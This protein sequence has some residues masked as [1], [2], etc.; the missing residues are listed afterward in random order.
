[1]AGAFMLLGI[2]DVSAL[3]CWKGYGSS[4]AALPAFSVGA[5]A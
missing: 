1:M 4:R 2:R 5:F 3:S